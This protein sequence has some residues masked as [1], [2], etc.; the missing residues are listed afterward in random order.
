LARRAAERAVAAGAGVLVSTGL[1]GGLT[2]DLARGEIVVDETGLRPRVE[3]RYRLARIISQDRVACTVAEKSAL[4][5]QG[6]AVEME[7]SAVR[8]VALRHGVKFAS[9]KVVSDLADEPMPMDFNAFR[10]SDGRFDHRRIALAALARP[11]VWPK[12]IRLRR[13]GLM[14][15]ERLGDFLA[16]CEF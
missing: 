8:E 1:C 7:S 16:H 11:W 4:A 6:V 9:V 13:E 14:A 2:P 5:G 3:Q 12:L 10:D 15:A